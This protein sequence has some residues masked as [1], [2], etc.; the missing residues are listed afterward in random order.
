[1]YPMKSRESWG[2]WVPL[3]PSFLLVQAGLSL[4]LAGAGRELHSQKNGHEA[5]GLELSIRTVKCQHQR[6]CQGFT[7]WPGSAAPCSWLPFLGKS[8]TCSHP[9]LHRFT[10]GISAR[11]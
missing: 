11:S 4:T 6:S 8:S 5:Q 9:P 2:Y 3:T 10:Q 7:A 1:M